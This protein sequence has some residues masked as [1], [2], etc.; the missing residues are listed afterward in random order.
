MPKKTTSEVYDA[1]ME[2]L[3]D[4]R[5]ELLADK[6]DIKL[7]LTG[8]LVNELLSERQLL[9]DV[10]VFMQ[11]LALTDGERLPLSAE[12]P[13]NRLALATGT[14]FK[15]TIELPAGLG[16]NSVAALLGGVWTARQ[17]HF[18]VEIVLRD[19]AGVNYHQLAKSLLS[20]DELTNARRIARW[21][22]PRTAQ[23]DAFLESMCN[24]IRSRYARLQ[25]QQA[26]V[27]AETSIPLVRQIMQ[28]AGFRNL[29]GT[30]EA[31]A[32]AEIPRG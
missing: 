9:G 3:N 16:S 15:K 26:A 25:L 6:L 23:Y 17:L 12:A 14:F 21:M 4:W 27:I 22:Q 20:V 18:D 24:T 28:N 11:V 30:D 5:S 13:V 10:P 29:Y 32:A 7:E 19:T 8:G 1:A 2:I 31:P